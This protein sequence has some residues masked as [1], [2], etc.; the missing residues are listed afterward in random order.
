MTA[1]DGKAVDRAHTACETALL[2]AKQPT[3]IVIS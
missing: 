1:P 2:M 3:V